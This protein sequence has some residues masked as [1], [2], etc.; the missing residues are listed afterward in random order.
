MPGAIDWSRLNKPFG[1]I[2]P[3]EYSP[4]EK[5]THGAQDL[6]MM[7]GM[8]PYRARHLGEGIINTS[9]L[10]PIANLVA[11]GADLQYHLPRGEYVNSAL[12]ALGLVPGVSYGNKFVKGQTLVRNADI[13]RGIHD[14]TYL[15]ERGTPDPYGMR[16]GGSYGPPLPSSLKAVDENKAAAT[17]YYNRVAASPVQYHP[18]ALNDYIL[19]T[20]NELRTYGPHGT[21]HT[22]ENSPEFYAALTRWYNNHAGRST[23]VTA[24]EFD[25]LRQELR[26]LPSGSGSGV[27][28]G[29]AANR[30]DTYMHTPPPGM[31]VQGNQ[32]ALDALRS[33]IENARG[34]WRAYETASP[35]EQSIVDAKNSAAVHSRDEGHAVKNVLDTYANTEAGRNAI[36]GATQDELA[37]IGAAAKG[38][39]GNRALDKIGD[40]LS[41]NKAAGI[42]GTAGYGL[43]KLLGLDWTTAMGAGAIGAG[44]PP[45]AGGL[46]RWGAQPGM[47]RSAQD[48]L[49]AIRMNSPLYRARSAPASGAAPPAGFGN[50][51]PSPLSGSS[52]PIENP[53]IMARD[54]VT[55]ALMPQIQRKGEDVWAGAHAPYEP[56]PAD[57]GRNAEPTMFGGWTLPDRKVIHPPIPRV[58][59]DQPAESYDPNLEQ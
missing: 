41:T 44:I 39:W 26:A 10:N 9:R 42:G 20:L 6:L 27:A 57:D 21:P 31:V 19:K 11:S 53:N 40:I 30:L 38:G 8:D 37:T 47:A 2:K 50:V 16:P 58:Y 5:A 45:A 48:A 3:A 22:P 13:P 43:G 1:E 24:L 28:G 51:G 33:N 29:K 35:I 56:V 54:A 18:T 14:P 12:D 52:A 49:D 7:G 23:P 15:P 55:Y 59:I 17:M 32:Q 4:T 46:M 25:N 36:Y 34:N